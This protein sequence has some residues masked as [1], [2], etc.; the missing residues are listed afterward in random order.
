M[1]DRQIHI[2]TCS[3]CEAMCGLEVHHAD[4]EVKLIRPNRDD[5]W[6]EG[7]ICPKGTVLGH[8]YA[9]PDRVRKPLVRNAAG[10]L[11]EASWGAALERCAELI[12]GVREKYGIEAITAYFGNATGF[13][14]SIS[15]YAGMFVQLAGLPTVYSSGTIDTWTK[16][17]ACQLMYGHPWRLL[18][19]DIDR[20]DFMVV[21][22]ANPA[23]SQG[24]FMGRANAP[25]ALDRVCER[26]KVVVIDP[27]R[28]ETCKHASQWLP[29]RPGTDALL[30]L[31]VVHVLFDEGLVRLGHLADRLKGIDEVAAIAAAFPPERVAEACGADPESIRTLA[32]EFAGAERAAWYA[33]IG[34]CNQEFGTLASWLPDVISALTGNLD[35]EG[36]MMWAKPVAW[37]MLQQ[38]WGFEQGF[39]RWRSRVRDIPEVLGQFPMGCLAEEIDTPGEGQIKGLVVVGGNPVLSAPNSDRLDAALPLLEAMI[40][41]DNALNETSRHAHVLL[42]GLAA[43]EQP[44]YS[45]L[46]WA[47]STRSAAKYA[48]PLFPPADDRP[49]EWEILTRLGAMCAGMGE[50]N[51]A[52]FDDLY[53]SALAELAGA[54][55][56][57]ALEASPTP[58]PERLNDLA[59]RTGPWGDRYGEDPDGLTLDKLK[60]LPNGIDMG[61]MI[62]QVD[63]IVL[64]P[65]AKIDLAPER[66]TADIERL[67][68]AMDRPAGSLMLTS[69]RHV[70]S[71]NSWMHNVEVL[72]RG[73]DRCT[74]LINAADAADAGVADGELARVSS[75]S[76]AV[77]VAVEISDEMLPGVVSLPHGW[78]HDKPG[79]R[80]SV[81]SRYA[82]VNYNVLV[83][84][85]FVDLPSGNA[86]INGVPVTVAPASS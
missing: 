31:A 35:R 77:E 36:G 33:R 52:E 67:V 19:P 9:D 32:R 78:G 1:T 11:A 39:D 29:I 34:T 80:Q 66:I 64:H 82:G 15:R 43:L 42:P 70:R 14:Y 65:D 40:S 55:P 28:S 20:T 18:V 41:V 63:D 72:V 10:E 85:D 74:L 53:F 46:L 13:N 4:G 30:Q 7:Y 83:P 81:A 75:R 16:N 23:A 26:G 73:K 12:G 44:F 76:G 58:G 2:R 61:P 45:E 56:A 38:D 48:P 57:V 71:N 50:V 27:R 59:I 8:M 21:Q 62:P 54:D 24:S 60:E 37:S 84:S 49:D 17:V 51:V 5:V 69:R 47:W 25:G 3:L 79:T 68:A 6:S 22:G 86:A